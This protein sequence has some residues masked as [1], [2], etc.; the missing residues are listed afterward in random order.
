MHVYSKRINI[1]I[2]CFCNP[3]KKP[4][5]ERFTKKNHFILQDNRGKSRA[6]FVLLKFIIYDNDRNHYN[7]CPAFDWLFI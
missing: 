5:V 6:E 4:A 3:L 1:V 2:S 7:M